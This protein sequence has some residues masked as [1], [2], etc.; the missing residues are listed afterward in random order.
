MK[1]AI[2]LA[3]LIALLTP[4]CAEQLPPVDRVQPY[5]LEKRHFVG[6]D[7]QDDADN[8]EFWTQ[9]TLVDVGYGAAQD[10]LF[11]STYAQ[12]LA[13]MRWK[14]TENLLLGRLAYERIQDSDGKGAG[15]ATNDGVIVVAYPI[16]SH[17]DIVR[18]YNPTTGEE[19]N[20]LEENAYDRPWYEREYMRV[21]WSRN[22]NTGSYDFDTLSLIGVY[23]SVTYEPLDYDVTDPNDPDAPVLD[24]EN[25]YFDVTN[26]AFAT[27]KLIDLSAFGWGI[28]AFPACFLD[29]DFMSGSYPAGNCN[30]VELTIRQSFRRVDEGDFEPI[31]WDGLRF[32]SYGAF[33]T[34][35]FG[36]ARNYGMADSLWSR[37][38]NHHRIWERSHY[39]QDPETMTG[40]VACGTAETT[41]FGEDPDRDLD[42]DG[43]ADECA[44]AGVG[45]RCDVYRQRCTLAFAQRTP[46]TLAWYYA[47]GSDPFYFE[48]TRD[49]AHQWDVALRQAVVSARYVECQ[50]TGGQDCAGRY[51]VLTGQQV[52]NEDAVALARDVDDCRAGRSH[53]GQG[54]EGLA[55]SLGAAR[56]VSAA[57][58]AL[59]RMPEML[60]LCHSPVEAGDP[61]ACGPEEVRLPRGITAA[62]CGQARAEGDDALIALCNAA[63]HVRRG[64][65]RY[66]QV[67]VIPEPQTPSPW[68]IMVDSIDPLS[69]MSVAASINVWSYINDLIS[70]LTLDQVRYMKG[71][72]NAA[73]V[74]EGKFVEDWAQAARAAATHGVL[75]KLSRAELNQLLADFTGGSPAQVERGVES[76]PEQVQAEARHA[77]HQVRAIRAAVDAPST[78]KAVYAAR[79]RAAAGTEFEASLLTP[80]VQAL[81]GTLGLPLSDSVLDLASPLR[82]ANPGMQRELRQ[83]KEEALARRGACILHP[84]E[85]IAPIS[86][87]ALADVLESKFERFN[88]SDSKAVQQ[89]RA[90]RMRQYLAR[91]MH[92]S[93]ITHEMGHSVGLRHNFVS[94]SDA[95]GFRP[96]YWQL[97]TR[98]GQVTEACQDLTPNGDTCVGPRYFDPVTDEE[99][100]GMIWMW[101]HS[102]IMEY[103]GDIT[104]DLLGL[105]AWDFAA[106]RMVYGDAAPVHADPSFNANTARGASMLDKMDNFG[107]ILGIQPTWG[108]DT[109]HYAQ[110]QSR[111]EL[112]RDCQTVAD[113]GAFRPATWDEEADGVWSPLLDGLMVKVNNQWSRCKQQP[114][115]FVDWDDL[116]MPSVQEGGANYFGGPSVDP[117]SRTR[118]PYGFA[119]DRWA[120]LGNVSVYRH[121]NGADPYEIFDFLITQQE[122]NYIFDRFRRGRQTF[123]VR[124]S[125]GRA[126]ER[127]SAKIRDGA[128]GLSLFRNYYEGIAYDLGYEF[129][130]L[131]PTAAGWYKENIIA[132]SM[133]FDHFART[134]DRPTPGAHFRRDYSELLFSDND[135]WASPGAT[136]VKI[137]SGVRGKYDGIVLGGWL[138]ENQLAEGQGEYDAEYTV[139]S[140]SYY[141]KLYTAMLMTESVDNFISDSRMDFI[142]PRYRAV[143]L[144]DLFPDGYRRWL[145]NNLTGDE[146]LKGWRVPAQANGVPETDL[147]KFAPYLGWTSWWPA[148]PQVCFPNSLTTICSDYTSPTSGALHPQAPADVAVLDPQVG[149]EQ[150]KFLIAWTMLYLPEN[151]EQNWLD[152]LRIWELGADADPGFGNRIELHDPNGKVYVA[153]TFGKEVIFGKVVQRGVAARVLEHANELLVAAYEVTDGPDLDGDGS[154][155]WHLPVLSPTTGQPVVKYDPRVSFLDE[156]GYVHESRPGC[157]ASDNSLCDCSS[158]RACVDLGHYMSVPNYLREALWAYQLGDPSQRGVY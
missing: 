115:D 85:S 103:P 33:T 23:G 133:A 145:A 24:L 22:L 105:G 92:M 79:R 154:P 47:D 81:T 157:N 6:E 17:F 34:D 3:T 28:D 5:A 122:V 50:R 95:F 123:S 56:G 124:G 75:P 112:I 11:T 25:G 49:A 156:E 35:R 21:D 132:S 99:R 8:P 36:F 86:L 78:H 83:L 153:K 53:G 111:L 19:L 116:R 62:Q 16:E 114:V 55:D 71:E 61:A 104:Q 129:S 138:V 60:V 43:T 67:N 45:S 108:G 118:V 84:D 91:R 151:E 63:R 80:M 18:A 148:S 10:G 32:Q 146:L 64:D 39:Y 4:A 139:N 31:H 69:G 9:G 119:T 38:L 137:P 127:Y 41:G 88:P 141:D 89:A 76:L 143:S 96:Q 121:D 149:W 66:H 58:I 37:F 100:N 120:D 93:V 144:A 128:K 14:I 87:P 1:R 152:L 44:A 107:G 134:L 70:Q 65:L 26:K 140:G 27:P 97:R 94:S 46:T 51:P 30:P 98:N 90:E 13:R 130:S 82:G 2:R 29:A 113:P 158:N 131:W 68:G 54:C 52:D 155:D 126:L 102:S 150:Q 77:R 147:A 106:T 57:V 12:P 142:D 59:A 72:L 110:M 74:T 101:M 117:Q 109:Y 48:P 15:R 125:S 20:V 136:L 135:S 7:L 42:Q 73:D 40:H